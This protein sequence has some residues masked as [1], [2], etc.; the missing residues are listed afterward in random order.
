MS[1]APLPDKDENLAAETATEGLARRRKVYD[2][3]KVGLRFFFK[4][5]ATAKLGH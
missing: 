4:Q 1:S 2:E 5:T 3:T